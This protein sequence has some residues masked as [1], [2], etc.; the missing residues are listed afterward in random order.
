MCDS[1]ML[2]IWITHLKPFD[3]L[4]SIVSLSNFKFMS[5]IFLR[6]RN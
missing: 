4:N 6:N 2:V 5:S 3:Y 1:S